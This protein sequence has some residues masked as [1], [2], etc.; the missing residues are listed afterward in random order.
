MA[1]DVNEDD[2]RAVEPGEGVMPESRLSGEG[3]IEMGGG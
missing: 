2:Q 3:V 1:Y